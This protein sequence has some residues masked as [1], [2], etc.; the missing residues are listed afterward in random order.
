MILYLSS[1][2]PFD[3]FNE[4]LSEGR[5]KTGHQAQKFNHLLIE[6][7]AKNVQVAAISNLPIEPNMHYVG[8]QYKRENIQY[9]LIPSKKNR[10][11]RKV[12]NVFSFRK[13][14]RRIFQ[15]QDVE[16]IICDAINL[17][18]SATAHWCAR[19]YNVPIIAI[20]TDVPEIMSKG[21]MNALMKYDARLM[22]RYD[23]YVLLTKPMEKIVNVSKCPQIIME[24]SSVVNSPLNVIKDNNP[25]I[26]LYTGSI[27]KDIGL[28]QL[29]EAFSSERISNAELQ[30]YGNGPWVNDLEDLISNIN[31]IKYCG[32][33]TNEE[34]MKRQAQADLLINPRPSNIHYAKYSF[35]SKLIEYLGTG[36]AV[37]STKLPGIP[38]DYEPYLYWIED[39]SIDGFIKSINNA[40]HDPNRDNFGK[41]A[42]EYVILNKSNEIQ[43]KRVLDLISI[44]RN[45]N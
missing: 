2:A 30:I 11:Q 26:C 1:V 35:P 7:L 6:G 28:E 16:A 4:L 25:K 8:G 39:E 32:V 17:G 42:R 31:K 10:I 24:G 20:V 37:L 12:S 36:T 9:Y 23:G 43:A 19:K 40:L 3:I 15:T 13:Y 14:A 22:K 5:I 18:A 41:K 21:N 27:C 44:V 33:L 38:E 45:G 34:I 29:I